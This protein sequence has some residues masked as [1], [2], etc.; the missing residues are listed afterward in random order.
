MPAPR[1]T[2][3]ALFLLLDVPYGAAVGFVTIAM[4]FLLATRGVPLE[5]YS[6][7]SAAANQPLTFKLAWMPLLD[8]G[9][10]RRRWYLGASV[11]TAVLL[12]ALAMV[13]DPARHLG[14]LTAL[15]T[16]S[17]ASATTGHAALNALVA[18]TTRAED[19]GRAAG[20]YMAS[21]V[22]STG[23]VGALAIWLWEHVAPAVAA[24]VLAAVVLGCAAFALRIEEPTLPQAR[25]GRPGFAAAAWARV[26]AMGRD[27]WQTVRSRQ[28]FTGLV[29]CLLPVGCGALTNLFSGL[30]VHYQASS[31]LVEWVSGVGGGLVGALGSLLGGQIGGRLRPRVAYALSG[32]VTAL[33]ALAMLAAPLT[34]ATYTW[35]TLLYGFANG[36]AFSTWAAMV[37]E[38]V[39]H[40]PAVTTKYA[41]F[42]A[43][44]NYA[45]SYVTFL[46]GRIPGWMG[47]TEARGALAADA[48]LT[49]AGIAVLAAI[50]A[51]TGPGPAR[52]PA[53]VPLS[54][55]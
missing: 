2:P 21:N 36:I 40:T 3:P 44:A 13:P 31:S 52:R 23:L 55:A 34:P 33:V 24:A 46:D 27:L 20:Y 7:L 25:G 6:L 29:L 22:G 48:V 17:M 53:G 10:W 18:I 41:L 39:G 26:A 50:L 1:P 32:G 35:G 51:W 16:L 42:N 19:K 9:S 49:V 5:T 15:M 47:W 4:P 12:V 37:L 28:G 11:V 14:L 38:M 8:V 30:A 43:A 45:I 54:G